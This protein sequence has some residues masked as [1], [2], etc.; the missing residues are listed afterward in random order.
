MKLVRR[1][2]FRSGLVLVPPPEELRANEGEAAGAPARADGAARRRSLL[3]PAGRASR[4]LPRRAAAGDAAF[5]N[6]LAGVV[7]GVGI[8]ASLL[9]RLIGVAAAG[10]AA[11]EG[12]AAGAASVVTLA[13]FGSFF[14]PAAPAFFAG[15]WPGACLAA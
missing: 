10:G 3:A 7:P 15:A 1:T 11:E 4:K 12:A 13:S 6:E 9:P 2:P 8:A 5:L 14:L